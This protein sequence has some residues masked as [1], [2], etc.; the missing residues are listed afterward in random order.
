MKVLNVNMS[1]DPVQGG[2]SVERTLQMSRYLARSGIECTV[3]TTDVGLTGDHPV[4]L[5]GVSL[6]KLKTMLQRY[7]LPRF[8]CKGIGRIVE[9]AD[10]IQLMN[11]WTFLNAVVYVIARRRNKPYVV[12][13]AGS[14]PYYGRSRTLK[15]IYN[16]V[17]GRRIVRNAHRCIAISPDE[18]DHFRSYGVEDDRISTIPNAI[19]PEDLAH[20]GVNTFRDDFGIGEAP[21]ILFVGRLNAIKGPDLLLKAFQNRL[22]CGNFKHDL[23]FA[24]PDGGMLTELKGMVAD[25]GVA[26]RVHFVGYLGNR[27]KSNAYRASD[28]LVIPS[29]QEAMS[30]V[31]LEAG[32]TKTPVLLTDRCGFD[33]V[34]SIGG[35]K[36]VPATVEGLEAGLA[37][38]LDRPEVLR[39]M[40]IR[41]YRY[42]SENF[43][44]DTMIKKYLSLYETILG[45][46]PWKGV[47]R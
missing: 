8:S 41:L 37:K 26:G 47:P 24:G 22:G 38:L 43:T 40:G 4:D 13:P 31:V 2:G 32:M 7:Y 15:R 46:A 3:L 42:V 35:G 29:R 34:E 10:I 39:P 5:E 17:I 33:A 28:L 19:R 12:C 9:R 18:I 14:L 36:V 45:D 25:M 21:F 16:T 23:V 6:I 27:D 30:I 1:C 44:W 20:E 11:H